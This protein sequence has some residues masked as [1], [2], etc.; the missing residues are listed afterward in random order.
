MM[1]RYEE[2]FNGRTVLNASCTGYKR[3][4][5]TDTRTP[6]L[7]TRLLRA[8]RPLLCLSTFASFVVILLGEAR[9][10]VFV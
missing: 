10:P 3:L 6:G 1:F 2:L 4:F 8:T 9:G 5:I 7:R